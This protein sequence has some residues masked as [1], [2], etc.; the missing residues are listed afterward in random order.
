MLTLW[1]YVF[2][3]LTHRINHMMIFPLHF[4]SL[5]NS[6]WPRSRST[7]AQ[8]MASCLTTP[9]YYLHQYWL[10]S[11]KVQWQCLQISGM[12]ISTKKG[13]QMAQTTWKENNYIKGKLPKI[14]LRTKNYD[15]VNILTGLPN[16]C[17][18]FADSN[19]IGFHFI[20]IDVAYLCR[21]PDFFP[22]CP[23]VAQPC[24]AMTEQTLGGNGQIA[25]PPIH[26]R[27]NAM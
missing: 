8:M 25:C 4:R 27:V 18:C 2:L 7:W 9:S 12:R 13:P 26:T 24:T 1:S 5:L 22:A 23:S 17:S 15:A 10:I 20:L 3:A 6:L 16:N 14:R 11:H 19:S 21:W